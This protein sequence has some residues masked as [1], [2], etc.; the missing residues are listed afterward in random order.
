MPSEN[1]VGNTFQSA[2]KPSHGVETAA[3]LRV[4]SALET[5]EKVCAV[6]LRDLIAAFD[7]VDHNLKQLRLKS[8]LG[9]DS[10]ALI[11]WFESY[12]SCRPQH[13]RINSSIS[14]PWF[15]DVAVP[16]GSVLGPVINVYCLYK[17]PTWCDTW[18]LYDVQYHFYVDDTQL[19][20]RLKPFQHNV[21]TGIQKKLEACLK[22]VSQWMSDNFL[23]LNEK[24]KNRVC[25]L[26]LPGIWV[27]SL[28]TRS[29][30]VILK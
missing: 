21:D 8:Q 15:Q 12:L 30:L 3:L 29:L 13:V 14:E 11:K 20:L 10:W 1:N 23:K 4:H 5:V 22:S 16:Q 26:A 7:T 6:E 9:I 18:I 27:N 25:L 17:P 2:Y 19:Y 24:K 28:L